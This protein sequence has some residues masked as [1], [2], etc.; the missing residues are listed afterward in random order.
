M[1]GGNDDDEGAEHKGKTEKLSGDQL[2]RNGENGLPDNC[3]NG[4]EEDQNVIYGGACAGLD[5]CKGEDPPNVNQGAGWQEIEGKAKGVQRSES[6]APKPN[7]DDASLA[8]GILP[9]HF[10][11]R[12]S[13][14]TPTFV[15]LMHPSM[16]T[17]CTHP[18]LH[19]HLHIPCEW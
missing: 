10:E 12:V 16:D 15:F 4:A 9:L 18:C 1:A 2:E 19:E 8:C 14:A 13:D 7:N 5:T 3:Q 11:V 6:M 17:S